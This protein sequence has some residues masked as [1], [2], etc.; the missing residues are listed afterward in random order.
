MAV[1]IL[2]RFAARLPPERQL[3]VA[4]GVSRNEIRKALAR[5]ESDGRLSREVGRGTEH[6]AIIDAIE[7]RDRAAAGEAMRRHLKTIMDKLM[8]SHP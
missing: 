1:G 3:A 7:Q 6:D 2:A 4:F 5:L 8:G